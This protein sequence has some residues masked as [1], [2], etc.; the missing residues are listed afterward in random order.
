MLLRRL[1]VIYVIRPCI[2]WDQ[3]IDVNKSLPFIYMN[4][5]DI[6]QCWYI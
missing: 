6:G 2:K 4:V 1:N 5:S 3:I